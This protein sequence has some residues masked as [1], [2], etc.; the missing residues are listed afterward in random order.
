MVRTGEKISGEKSGDWGKQIRWRFGG[1]VKL[2]HNQ[3]T[4]FSPSMKSGLLYKFGIPPFSV[5]DARGGA[6]LKRKRTWLALGIQSELGRI[7]DATWNITPRGAGTGK[8]S[9]TTYTENEGRR[10]RRVITP[11]V[12]RVA[13]QGS[14]K[15]RAAEQAKRT[16]LQK[17]NKPHGTFNTRDKSTSNYYKP[18]LQND[19]GR[20]G[21]SVFDPVLC[22][23]MYRWFCPPNGL[24]LDPFA[25]GS[26]RG[27]VASLLDF[28]YIGID[29][30][31]EQIEANRTQAQTICDPARQP[32]YLWG[33]S[34]NIDKLD[35][36]LMSDF[37]FSCPPYFNL[38][39]YSNNPQDL[40]A[41]SYVDFLIAYRDIIT[42]S[43]ARLRDNRFAC[44][45]VS[46]IRDKNDGNYLRL[47]NLTT[48]I[49]QEC[50]LRLYNECVLI[51]AFGSLA[52]RVTKQFMSTRKVG[53]AH[54]NVLIFL[55]GD[56]RKVVE[57]L[58]APTVDQVN[59]YVAEVY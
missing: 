52:I 3:L 48:E 18:S 33:N 41:M 57:A 45:V 47:T 28:D 58:G 19:N 30:S 35:R 37:I 1:I 23:M 36:N 54:Q 4:H 5:L 55:K 13:E 11:K 15:I 53:K 6:W 17:N 43:C 27:I 21:T 14:L 56:P 10:W 16:S 51:T 9:G 50:G 42:K 32:R 34:R 40:S 26:V 12:M 38:E 59:E 2:G 25:G 39:Q 20:Y 31:K 46:D 44:F 49:F 24:I 22:E 8:N 7:G 29:L